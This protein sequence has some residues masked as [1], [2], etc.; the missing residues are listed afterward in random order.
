MLNSKYTNLVLA[1]FFLA[2]AMI[3]PGAI[4]AVSPVVGATISPLHIPV[5]LCG[6]ICGKRYGFLVGIMTPIVK[7][8]IYGVPALFVAVP[9]CFELATYGFLTGFMIEKLGKTVKN[10]YI[11]LITAMIGGRVIYGICTYFV[12][13][14]MLFGSSGGEYTIA[15]FLTSGALLGGLPGIIAHIIIVPAIVFAVSNIK[16]LNQQKAS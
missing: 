4:G 11:S 5:L 1:S 2:L 14:F 8:M 3:L 13:S 12:T 16:V 15:M 10:T 9:M 7:V 6:F